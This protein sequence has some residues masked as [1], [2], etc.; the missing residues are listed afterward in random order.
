MQKFEESQS[1]NCN[2][3][4]QGKDHREDLQCVNVRQMD[5]WEN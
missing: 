4:G 1:S 2:G 5:S 3:G